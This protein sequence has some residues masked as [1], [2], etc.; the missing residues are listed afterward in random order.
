MVHDAFVFLSSPPARWFQ[1]DSGQPVNYV[2]DAAGD[3]TLG[4]TT[5]RAAADAAMAAWTNVPTSNLVLA[6]AGTTTT[7]SPFG[8][9][10]TNQV[11]FNDPNNE[12]TDPS[13][14]GGI[15]AIGG[16][17]GSTATTVVNGTTFT[18]ILVGKVLFNNGWGGCS[19]WNQCNVSEV[20]THEFGHSIGLG[21]STD[22][23]ATMWA[24]AHFDGRCAGLGS[25]DAAAV[26]FMYPQPAAQ[27]PVSGATATPTATQSPT[28]AATR[29]ATSSPTPTPTSSATRT[30]TPTATSAPTRTATRT[31]T[32]DPSATPTPTSAPTD[33][34]TPTATFTPTAAATSTPTAAFDVSG[35]ILYYSNGLPVSGATVDLQGL[36]P[37][38]AVT[39]GSGQFAFVGVAS[40]DWQLT[41]YKTGDGGTAID[42]LDAVYALQAALGLRQ[43]SPA[44]QIACNVSGSGTVDVLDAVLILQY[45]IGLVPHFPA[46]DSCGS[47]W[48]FVPQPAETLNESLVQPQMISGSCVPGT[49]TFQPLAAAAADQN[50]AAVLF[51]DCTG[52]WQPSTTGSEVTAS[53]PVRLGRMRRDARAARRSRHVR[54]P[55]SV[56]TGAGFRA[57]DVRLRYDSTQVTAVNVEALDAARGALLALNRRQ[58]GAVAV[59]LASARP[60][61]GGAVLMLD[62]QM[63]TGATD[64]GVEVV[65]A[66]VGM[67]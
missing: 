13:G 20:A 10:D 34:A 14:C 48:T 28:K 33:T 22:P 39:D 51:G 47:N 58:P 62:F 63:A 3:A 1:P 38:A 32:S 40:G 16:Y 26:T 30:S 6:D 65:R 11:V 54:V 64:P 67:N 42:V 43:L 4:P 18:Q 29:M 9:C 15:L 19:F 24:T 37:A 53:A 45:S 59:A 44:Q 56:Q 55:V 27:A 52:R 36:Q 25:D 8:T 41:P 35:T 66:V 49:I 31:P 5:S 21:H 12:I 57:L 50:F 7:P 61:P 17:C 23:N 2:V 46:V 60:L